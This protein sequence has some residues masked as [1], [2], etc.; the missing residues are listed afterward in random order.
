M[1]LVVQR[2]V[3][4]STNKIALQMIIQRHNPSLLVMHLTETN[5]TSTGIR[6][7]SIINSVLSKLD[8]MHTYTKFSDIC[9]SGHSEYK[10]KCYRFYR[11]ESVIFPEA[12]A[13]CNTLN[14]GH[15]VAYHSAEDYEFLKSLIG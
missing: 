9:P 1:N 4:V 13:Y 15:V 6:S 3:E 8:Y 11:E 10:G 2:T 14:E 12:E 5:V 7:A